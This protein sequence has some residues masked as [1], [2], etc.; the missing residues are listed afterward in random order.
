MCGCV[1]VCVC[2][3]EG[4]G[5]DRDNVVWHMSLCFKTSPTSNTRC[6]LWRCPA[7]KQFQVGQP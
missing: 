6:G 7:G 2:V 3:C 1:C 5:L 4:E